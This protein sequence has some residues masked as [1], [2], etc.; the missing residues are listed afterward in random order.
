MEEII[1]M[2]KP[3]HVSWND[4]RELLLAAHKK[5]IESGM[6]M[7]TTTLSGDEIRQYLG[8][9][10]RCFVAFC[11]SRLV[12]TTSVR[13]SRG[14]HWYDKG[15]KIAMGGL[16][17]ILPKYQGL[18][19]LEEM[20][21]LRDTYISEQGVRIIEG[22][23]AEGNKVVRLSVAKRGFK[24]VRFF[25]ATH[26]EHYSVQFVKWLDDCPFSD[27]FI[28][29]KFKESKFLTKLQYKPGKVERSPLISYICIILRRF[30]SI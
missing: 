9:E 26:Q 7:N 14:K 12:G 18:G 3:D 21:A 2:P 13:I 4:I 25:P 5:N 16:S 24:E 17:A 30:F 22:D 10:G 23:T 1:V 15:K 20:N 27:A 8:E 29:R 11:G 28:R 19:I 6:K